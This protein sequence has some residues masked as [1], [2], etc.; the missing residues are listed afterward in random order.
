MENGQKMSPYLTKFIWKNSKVC[1]WLGLLYLQKQRMNQVYLWRKANNKGNYNFL[2]AF[3][4]F[5]KTSL[6]FRREYIMSRQNGKFKNVEYSKLTQMFT[7]VFLSNIGVD[8]DDLTK[9]NICFGEAQL[10]F[11]NS[12]SRLQSKPYVCVNSTM[13]HPISQHWQVLSSP[14]PFYGY[15]PFNE[16]ELILS[17]KVGVLTRSCQKILKG[18]VS[19]YRQHQESVKIVLHLEDPLVFCYAPSTEKFDVIDCSQIGDN[20]GLPNVIIAASQRLKDT[21]NAMLVSESDLWSKNYP[22]VVQYIE[23]ALLCPVSFI[24]TIYGLRL[25]G[26]VELGA[27]T[28][29]GLRCPNG[30]AVQLFWEKTPT[31]RHGTPYSSPV[32]VRCLERIIFSSFNEK[33]QPWHV[34]GNQHIQGEIKWMSYTPL[35]F[36]YLVDSLTQ[37]VGNDN[38]LQ[39]VGKLSN[40][41]STFNLARRTIKAWKNGQ[42]VVKCS[43]VH[44]VNSVGMAALKLALSDLEVN[45]GLCRL[46]LIFVP[47]KAKLVYVNIPSAFD[48]SREFPSIHESSFYPDSH[49]VDNIQFDLRKNMDDETEEM[50]VSFLLVPDHGIDDD[51]Y[52][53]LLVDIKTSILVLPV[54]P[55][56]NMRVEKFTEPYP[57]AAPRGS[58]F[59]ALEEFQMKVESCIETEQLFTL[60]IMIKSQEDVSGKIFLHFYSLFFLSLRLIS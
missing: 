27:A 12:S 41:A 49:F 3:K 50:S 28:D 58:P 29:I 16:E 1:S 15:A 52:F 39:E 51:N 18:L 19:C 40:L 54:S 42:D 45:F 22:S 35:T 43:I 6:H 20:C 59:A 32:L 5:Y 47:R 48:S 14:F 46:R 34:E 8:L 44:K 7:E 57:F 36:E 55:L 24:P 33:N 53:G 37:R 25:K 38:W 23:K 2:F 9:N 60:K 4:Q 11:Q 10:F 21:P 31:F 13:L 30:Y 26:H 17:A 56:K